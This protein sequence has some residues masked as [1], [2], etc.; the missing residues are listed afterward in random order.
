MV[1]RSLKKVSKEHQGTSNKNKTSENGTYLF[2][3]ET[4]GEFRT[5]IAV[6][7]SGYSF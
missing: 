1:Y 4:V 2:L 7:L 3:R 5:V 6:V